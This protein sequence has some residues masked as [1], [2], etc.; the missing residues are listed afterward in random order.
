M[1]NK[2]YFITGTDTE[3]GKTFVTARLARYFNKHNQDIGVFKPLMSGTRRENPCSDAYILKS[4][5]KVLDGLEEINPFQWD[6]ALAPALA[7]KRAKTDYSLDDVLK[8]YN[9]LVNKEVKTVSIRAMKTRW[10]SCNPSKSY[11]NLN[12]ELIKKPKN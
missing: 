8:K 4:G 5:A 11:I 9:V 3:I 1:K 2:G 10:G 6:E 12:L 7:Q